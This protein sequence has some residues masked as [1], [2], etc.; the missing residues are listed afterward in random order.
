VK[1]L[2]IFFSEKY[3]DNINSRKQ[4]DIMALSESKY[5]IE[6]IYALSDGQRAELIDGQM[7]MSAA[8]SSNH[9]R[10]S[11][12]LSKTIG[13]YIDD[14][15][16]EVFSAPFGVFLNAKTYIEPDISVICDKDKIIEKGCMGAPDWTIEIVSKG[17]PAYDY[18]T[19]QYLYCQAKVRE[20]W[21]VDK[22]KNRIM[23]YNFENETMAEYTFQDKVK[24]GIYEDFEIDF[25]KLNII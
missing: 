9:Q 17:N 1:Y 20:Y 11:Q 25:S 6:D 7:Y 16:G 5:T 24:A 2:D 3:N 10:I 19:K 13:N 21:I 22:D 23:V 18:M 15:G 4:G 12:F 8:P 14:K